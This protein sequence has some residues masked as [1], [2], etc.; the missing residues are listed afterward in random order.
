MV[1]LLQKIVEKVVG[2]SD[3]EEVSSEE[4]D[5]EEIDEPDEPDNSQVEEECSRVG[6]EIQQGV[7][8]RTHGLLW[9]LPDDVV[10]AYNESPNG[11]I[12]PANVCKGTAG[13]GS[14]V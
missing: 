2:A 4:T 9:P 7:E 8:G 3:E 11:R 6:D 5:V 12:D 14:R 1:L 13:V 10:A